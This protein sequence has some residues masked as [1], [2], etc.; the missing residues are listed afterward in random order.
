[1]TKWKHSI[2]IN[3]HIGEETSNDAIV[4]AAN[5]VIEELEKLPNRYFEDVF[6]FLVLFEDIVECASEPDNEQDNEH[7]LYEFNHTLSRLYDWGDN[8]RIWLGL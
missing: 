7:I 4:K 8:K 1:M 5:G 2:N 6:Y 3:Q